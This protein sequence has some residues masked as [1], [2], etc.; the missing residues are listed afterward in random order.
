VEPWLTAAETAVPQGPF[1]HGPASVESAVCFYRALHRCLDGDL[2]AAESAGRR[3]AELEL[4]LG[5]R[6][7][8]ARTLALLG[9][10]LFWR[11]HDADAGLLLEQ[12]TRSA[13]W[14][15]DTQARQLALSCM[16]AI[17]ARQCEYEAATRYAREAADLA[18]R[19]RVTVVADLTSADLLADR[20]ELA[21][22][23]TVAL[24]ALDHAEHKRW[25]LDT[26]AA[27]VCLARIY[28]R[29]GR[30]ADARVRLGEASDLMATL[31]DP[32]VL[33]G[34]LAEAKRSADQREPAPAPRG[35]AQRPDGLTDREAEILGL[36]TRGHTNLEIAAKLV[37]SVHTVERHLQNAYRKIGVR[38]RA[39]ASAYMARDGS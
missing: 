3:A 2:T 10:I 15:A 27:L 14:L 5:N 31:P 11:G 30:A 13:H 17:S 38:N 1:R 8:R 21:A 33:V 39:D 18:E 23:E 25:R 35:R 4:E 19:L 24:A 20:D 6:F 12:V 37:I 36:L 9:A 26:G 29:A 7:W 28:T 22:A 34:L 32:G 16:A